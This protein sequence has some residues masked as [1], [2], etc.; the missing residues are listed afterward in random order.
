VDGIEYD[1]YFGD[2]GAVEQDSGGHGAPT[3]ASPSVEAAARRT[4][5]VDPEADAS[6]D[7]QDAPAS[8]YG[9]SRVPSRRRPSGFKPEDET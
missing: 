7:P 2:E 4:S 9:L 6:A 1:Y 5:T 8:V 3:R